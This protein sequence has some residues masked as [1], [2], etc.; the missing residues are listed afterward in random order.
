MIKIDP[1]IHFTLIDYFLLS[2]AEPFSENISN[3]VLVFKV[4]GCFI[5][6]YPDIS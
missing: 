3:L 4:T 1:I 6:E 5:L 2:C